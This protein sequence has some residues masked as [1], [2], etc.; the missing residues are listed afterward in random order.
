M[1]IKPS[2][3]NKELQMI[4]LSKLKLNPNNLRRISLDKLCKSIETDLDMMELRPMVVY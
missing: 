2:R 4:K 3:R 1:V